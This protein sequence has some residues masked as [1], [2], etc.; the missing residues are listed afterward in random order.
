MEILEKG[1]I[2]I[3]SDGYSGPTLRKR[4]LLEILLVFRPWSFT[5]TAISVTVGSLLGLVLLGRFNIFLGFLVLTGIIA[6]HA[7]GN[8][9]NDYCDT[10]HGVD[11]KGAPTTLYRLH[12][13][14]DKI[15]SAREIIVSAAGLY[16]FAGLIGVYLIFL[17][18]W[19]VALMAAA[20]I[21]ASIEY[22]APP[23]KYKYRGLG[24]IVVFFMWGPIMTLGVYYV[25]TG[26]WTGLETVL[27]TSLPLGIWVALVLL[28][29][30]LKDMRYDDEVKI[31]TLPILIGRE[32]ALMIIAFMAY[33]I[34][35]LTGVGVLTGLF[36]PWGLLVFLTFPFAIK[37]VCSFKKRPE[38]PHNADQK[39]AHAF[40]FYGG[41]LII[42][43]IADY[44]FL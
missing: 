3:K 39:T 5:M 30:N 29:N 7:A 37:L 26:S 36:S 34:Y 44:L 28:V 18:G 42:S 11:K 38:L 13:L 23:L 1:K 12:P 9:I 43:I 15:L 41:L 31:M 8:I 6:V 32:K 27:I 10:L 24:E 17:R 20:G 22:T 35:I 40:T 19:P 14:F 16:I 2:L 25:Q 21:I 33:S 4:T